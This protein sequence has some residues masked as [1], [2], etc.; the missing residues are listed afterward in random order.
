MLR[1]AHETDVAKLTPHGWQEHFQPEV[2]ADRDAALAYFASQKPGTLE[3]PA[4]VGV[5]RQL[6]LCQGDLL[7][8]WGE[9]SIAQ[10]SI[11]RNEELP[12]LF[13][14]VTTETEKVMIT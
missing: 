9:C 2:E 3:R 8:E 14:G 7:T 13:Q 11:D 4:K 12:W 5:T 1:I 10:S 6:R